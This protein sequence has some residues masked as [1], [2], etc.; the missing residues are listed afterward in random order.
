MKIYSMTATFGKLEHETL[1]LKP[2]LNIIE[3]PNEWGKSTWS[4]FL[5]AMFYGLD[6]RAK[7][8]KTALAD[9]ERFAPWSGAPMAGRIDLNWKG[10]D[11]TI[12][13]QTRRRIP[14]GEFRAYETHTGLPVPELTAA[15]CGQLLLGVEQSVFR[16]SGFI[17]H[18]DLPVTQDEALRRR[19]NALVTTGDESGA[20]QH[21]EQ[22]LKE[23]RNRCRYNRSGLLPQAEAQQ[24]ALERKLQELDNLNTQSRKL[25]LRLEELEQQ[26]GELEN[27]RAALRYT[28]SQADAQR[29]AQARDARDQGLQTLTRLEHA[30]ASVPDAE[31]ARREAARLEELARQ[32]ED[33]Q[34][35]WEMLPAQ[36]EEPRQEP[37]FTGLTGEE[38]LQMA[39]ADAAVWQKAAGITGLLPWLLVL[40]A[41]AACGAVYALADPLWA[42]VPG[43]VAVAA[44]IVAAIQAGARK[45]R[46]RSLEERYGTP[47][48]DA[49]LEAA[50]LHGEVLSRHAEE[51]NSH[52]AFRQELQQRREALRLQRQEASRGQSPEKALYLWN[53]AIRCHEA[54][55]NALRDQQRLEDHLQALQTMARK[56][57]K[58]LHRS[59]LTYT[60]AQTATLLADT[61]AERQRLQQRLHQYRGQMEALGDPE[62]LKRQLAAVRERIGQLE[63]HYAA[64]TI[65]QET[66]LEARME[67]QRRFAPRIASRAQQLLSRMTGGRYR[68]LSLGED[69]SLRTGAETEDILQDAWWRSD[70]TVDQL[71]LALRLAVAEELTP[72]APLIL[73]DA[74]VR[75][76]DER[77]RSALAILRETAE[78]KQV[79]L[80][81][82][83]SRESKLLNP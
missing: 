32:W 29:V 78:E 73:D 63:D 6:T 69:L 72:E 70:G 14:L 79:I 83:Q 22:S 66:L 65:A 11:I 17:R 16:R 25:R 8:T 27:H 48:P 28:A 59:S 4:A 75:F 34:L 62:A 60:E 44:G 19:L 56:A 36:P 35:E 2:G 1:T 12:Q 26:C 49:W 18:S 74:L 39:Q 41:L 53:Q 10:R 50:R 33:L 67:L 58:P 57:E 15:N 23:L 42:L 64:L 54:Y 43:L 38:A 80:F 55:H 37:P 81:T 76:D 3:A 82:C 40:L 30:A 46:R 61:L 47:D 7:T 52:L 31:T 77:L 13:R 51:Q 20:A 9:K 71:Y 45:Q 5:L 68:K 24:D 21:L